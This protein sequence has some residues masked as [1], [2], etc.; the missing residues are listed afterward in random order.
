MIKIDI[1]NPSTRLRAFIKT[2]WPKQYV[3]EEG[4]HCYIRCDDCELCGGNYIITLN[5]DNIGMIRIL[6][7]KDEFEQVRNI[8]KNKRRIYN[9][10]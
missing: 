7:F 3:D 5:A 8:N 1:I 2:V 9:D 4:G 6:L 10:N